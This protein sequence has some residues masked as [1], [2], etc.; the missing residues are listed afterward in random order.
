[1]DGWMDSVLNT[2]CHSMRFTFWTMK[3]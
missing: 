1:M 3:S 2:A